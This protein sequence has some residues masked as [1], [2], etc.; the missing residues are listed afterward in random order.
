MD[1][2]RHRLHPLPDSVQYPPMR[3][4]FCCLLP[5]GVFARWKIPSSVRFWPSAFVSPSGFHS[6]RGCPLRLVA[7]PTTPSADFSHRFP[8]P[9]GSGSYMH[10]VRSP[11]VMR[12]YFH[13]YARRIYADAF[14]SGIGLSS[15]VTSHPASFA[16]YAVS[17]RRASALLRASF[18][19]R[20]AATPLPFAIISR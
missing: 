9:P 1:I 17:V 11:R 13:A 6:L 5:F 3:R 14:R 8:K 12:H 19:P 15:D 7:P 10:N 4:S 18:R 2:P 20:L 16:S